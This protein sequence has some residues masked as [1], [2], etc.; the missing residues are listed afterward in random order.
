MARHRLVRFD[1]PKRRSELKSIV[2]PTDPRYPAIR[3]RM[4]LTF[5][6]TL[7][8]YVMMGLLCA[9]TLWAFSFPFTGATFLE[10]VGWGGIF[11]FGLPIA[12]WWFCADLANW[13]QKAKPADLN[14][15]DHALVQ[16]CLDRAYA[17]SDLSFKPPLYASP[18]DRP[19]AW[20]TGPIHRKA[21]VGFTAGLLKIG[22]SED[23][24]TGVFA[25]ELGHVRNY[26]VALN[27][28]T[29][30]FSMFFFL[31]INAGLMGILGGIGWARKLLGLDQTGWFS[32]LLSNLLLFPVF[33]LTSQLTKVVQV[34]VVRSRESGA[35]ATGAYI[36]G[37]PCALATALQKLAAYVS[38]HR[39]PPGSN[40]FGIDQVMRP[41]MIIDPLFDSNQ[42]QPEPKGLWQRLV[43]L[44]NYLQ[45]THPPVAERV[46]ELERMNGGS[47]TVS[48]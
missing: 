27:S 33:W 3:R 6:K 26:D 43:A 28:I 30:L 17:D 22:L 40:Q 13:I 16:R 47:C 35:D 12:A 11:W 2:K 34:F 42:V 31:T 15:P 23:E 37:N 21:K 1:D 36:T 45:L 48:S 18:D 32:N 14:N 38:T 29:S 19:N 5:A 41:M 24:I 44:W 20:A 10:I 8:G 7:L 39:P 25:H 46:A 4:Q 9:V